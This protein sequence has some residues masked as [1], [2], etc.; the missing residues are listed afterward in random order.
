MIARIKACGWQALAL[1]LAGLLLWQ[2]LRLGDAEVGLAEAT[3]AHAQ[4]LSQA[5]AEALAN[6]SRM[7]GEKDDAIKAAEKRATQ[8]AAAADLA[9][10]AA[11]GLR[12]DLASAPARIAAAT[13]AAVDE[14]AATAGE[15]LGVCTAEYQRVAAAADGHANDARLMLDAWPY[16]LAVNE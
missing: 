7:E 3:A 13:R 4:A 10:T 9:R 16:Q 5:N 2:T 14:Y 8:N 6:Y 12:R 1:G 15:L 11:D